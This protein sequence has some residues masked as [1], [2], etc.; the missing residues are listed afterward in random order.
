MLIYNV[1]RSTEVALRRDQPWRVQMGLQRHQ[2]DPQGE[3]ALA[4]FAMRVIRRSAQPDAR[5][6]RTATWT[7]RVGAQLG[8]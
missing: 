4:L 2:L 7:S 1:F 3:Y 5:H 6:K 8:R